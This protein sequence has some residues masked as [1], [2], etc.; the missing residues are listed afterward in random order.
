ML[1]GSPE[2]SSAL[3]QMDLTQLQVFASIARYALLQII[4]GA[5]TYLWVRGTMDAERRI[6]QS[7]RIHVL[8]HR[9]ADRVRELDEGMRHVLE[10]SVRVA[11]GDLAARAQLVPGSLLFPVYASLNTLLARL[12][13]TEREKTLLYRCIQ[14]LITIMRKVRSGEAVQ[15]GEWPAA[16]GLPIDA[17]AAELHDDSLSRGLVNGTQT[18]APSWNQTRRASQPTAAGSPQIQPQL[19]ATM[20]VPVGK[21]EAGVPGTLRMSQAHLR[22]GQNL[23]KSLQQLNVRQS[24]GRGKHVLPVNYTPFPLPESYPEDAGTPTRSPVD[25]P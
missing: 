7:Q 18:A 24:T 3:R 2:V 15:K 23:A 12:E 17:L 25:T 20:M 22:R 1:F 9:D 21:S 14:Q 6:E 4:V 11:N 5:M 13:R 8:E 16:T 19:S 10:T